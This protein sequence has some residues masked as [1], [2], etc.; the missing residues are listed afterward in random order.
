MFWTWFIIIGNQGAEKEERGKRKIFEM[1][2]E[3]EGVRKMW[4][5]K[6]KIR[7]YSWGRRWLIYE[8]WE[9][10]QRKGWIFNIFRPSFPAA[11]KQT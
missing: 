4:D 10:E 3:T 6:K 1:A 8:I 9:T 11:S 5:K 7:W 2:I